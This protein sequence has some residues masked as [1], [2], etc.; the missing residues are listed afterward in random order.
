MY[1]LNLVFALLILTYGNI[2]GFSQDKQPRT[3]PLEHPELV[4]LE[5]LPRRLELNEGPEVLRAPYTIKS[6][7]YFRLQ[8]TN[9]SLKKIT[10]F[11]IDTYYQNRLELL[12]GGEIVSYKDGVDERL[13]AREKDPVTRLVQNVTLDSD[14]SR[15]I[16]YLYLDDWYGQLQPGHYRLSLKHRFE[17]GR[18]WIES[19]SVTFEVLGE[20]SQSS[21]KA[22]KE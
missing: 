3:Y 12:R 13:R 2:P 15:V 17:P 19:S 10:L 22:K 7:I 4:R 11:I 6:K 9:T 5:L 21:S 20:P 14:E 18:D 1:K 8:A 16:E